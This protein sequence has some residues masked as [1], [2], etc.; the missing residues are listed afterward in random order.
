LS[1]PLQGTNLCQVYGKI[2]KNQQKLALKIINI[3]L[4]AIFSTI[5]LSLQ[6]QENKNVDG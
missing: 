1:S 4:N 3:E 5:Q 6:D 2:I